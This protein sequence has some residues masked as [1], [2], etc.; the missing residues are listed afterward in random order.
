MSQFAV[1]KVDSCGVVR[2]RGKHPALNET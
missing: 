1:A 2:N